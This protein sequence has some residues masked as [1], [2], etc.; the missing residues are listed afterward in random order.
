MVLAAASS[1]LPPLLAW[2][3]K[4]L[5]DALSTN[6]RWGAVA[7]A[8]AGIGLLAAVM[9]P[10]SDYNRVELARR[11]AVLVPDRLFSALDR[12]RGLR[13]FDEP[14]SYD[15]L[16]LAQ[17]AGTQAPQIL[18]SSGIGILQ[19]VVTIVGFT[20]T[21]AA[22]SLGLP[23]VILLAAFPG[24]AAQLLLSRAR[25]QLTARVSRTE[26]RRLFFQMLLTDAL[27]AKETRLFGS[28]R[29]L[30]S[31]MVGELDNIAEQERLFDLRVLKT[32]T[33][34]A[35][36]SS[37]VVA[38]AIFWTAA[39]V[40]SERLSLGD[41]AIVLAAGVGTQAVLVGLVE[42]VGQV[43]HALL[44][45][46]SYLDVERAEVD[47]PDEG[48]E[49]P[50]LKGCIEFRDV[51]FRYAS[52]ALWVLRGL[53]LKIHAGSS[54]A[55][56]GLN[57]S[58]KS[59]VVKLLCRMYDPD[60]GSIL[61]NGVDIR[62][63]EPA[64]LRSQLSAVFQD[65][66]AYD[67]TAA[68][69]I[70]IADVDNTPSQEPVIAAAERAGIADVIAA[71]PHGYDTMLTRIFVSDSDRD[72]PSTGVV[73]SG[74][75]WQRLA[76]ARGLLRRD[77]AL[78]ILDEPSSGLDPQAEFDVQTRLV[79]ARCSD[80][81]LLITHRLGVLRHVD[82]IFVIEGGE[83][84]ETGQHEELMQSGGMYAELFGLQAQNYQA[85]SA[86]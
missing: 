2:S 29:Y 82:N 43:Q 33:V 53:S 1:V 11:L 25:A 52:D 59:T 12:L 47:L 51:W 73:P 83:C 71:M 58:G 72:D 48:E 8:V 64:A 44:L 38:G 31:R 21:L 57:G 32:H 56:V 16:Q 77:A 41:L 40:A 15:S 78:L 3:T 5:I 74:G 84:I 39:Q 69:N 62:R 27:A 81:M 37:F 4:L 75:Q 49:L 46:A 7:V 35:W 86:D 28:G 17:Q 13:C 42:R 66:M 23:G 34:L 79:Q 26:R 6:R 14:R 19:S 67:L 45:F 65:F 20:L 55:L 80:T 76:L 54:T 85:L 50:L 30:R 22:V 60:R 36:A 70:A 18:V 24:L 9:G 10:L 63:V 61:W 68:E